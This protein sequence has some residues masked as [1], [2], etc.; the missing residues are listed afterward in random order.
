LKKLRVETPDDVETEIYRSREFSKL[1]KK[2]CGSQVGVQPSGNS[3]DNGKKM[4]MGELLQMQQDS[5]DS[6]F[7]VTPE[8]VTLFE[9]VQKARQWQERAEQAQSQTMV[10]KSL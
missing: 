6:Y 7:I 2:K 5:I 9:Y 8:M 1:I 10:L 4:K 3:N